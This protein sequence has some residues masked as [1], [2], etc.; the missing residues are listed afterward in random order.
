ME[1][2]ERLKIRNERDHMQLVE[3]IVEES[4]SSWRTTQYDYF[5]KL[6]NNIL[7]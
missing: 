1:I 4:R 7:Y 6:T 2:R 5:Q 3:R